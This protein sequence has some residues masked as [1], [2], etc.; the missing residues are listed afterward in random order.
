MPTELQEFLLQVI[1]DLAIALQ[2]QIG[3]E[4]VD[5]LSVDLGNAVYKLQEILRL[6]HS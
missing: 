2:K 5:V 4:N 1:A 3:G 6:I